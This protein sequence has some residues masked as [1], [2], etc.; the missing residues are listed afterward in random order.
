LTGNPLYEEVVR[1]TIAFVERELNNGEGGFYSALDADSLDISGRLEEGAFYVWTKDEFK[2]ILGDD[3]DI[4]C[5][6]FNINEFGYWE[7]DN[8]VLIQ[9]RPLTELAKKHKL[10]EEILQSKKQQ[11][12]SQ[13]F[14]AREQRSKP[15][16]DDK[17]LTSWNAIMLKGYVDA[18]KA[19][20][21]PS[22]LKSALANGAFIE[23]RLW[24]PEGNLFRSYKKEVSSINAYLEDYAHV[25][26]AFIS[27]YEVTFDETWLTKARQLTDYCFDHFY[28]ENSKFFRFTSDTDAELIAPH[29]EIE[30]NVIPASNSVM[31]DSL[32]RLGI[33][34]GNSRY[35]SASE[36]MLRHIVPSIDYPSAFANWLYLF[37]DFAGGGKEIAVCGP[38]ANEMMTKLNS[39]Y[40]PHITSASTIKPSTLPFLQGRFVEN[41]TLFYVCQNKTC[42][43]PVPD[44]N[45]A[46]QQLQPESKN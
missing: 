38:D 20:M 46:L 19:F 41:Q 17:C 10:P 35:E 29:F 6:V 33:L 45:K 27:L 5:D 2:K 42:G 15:R 18:Y 16:L 14:T 43:L 23:K 13:L 26:A 4:F 8:Y 3:F 24:S 21:D 44:Y 7:H 22:Y 28:D 32:Y 1:K 11:W 39:A 40:L 34:F 30:D 9:N 31:A 36:N 37:M 25:T 12:E